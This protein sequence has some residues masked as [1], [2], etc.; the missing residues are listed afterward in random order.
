MNLEDI[1]KQ[2][3]KAHNRRLEQQFPI[4][5]YRHIKDKDNN[6]ETIWDNKGN[7]VWQG[8]KQRDD[9]HDAGLPPVHKPSL[10]HPGRKDW[11]ETMQNRKIAERSLPNLGK[12][13]SQGGL[14][15]TS[16]PSKQ[17]VQQDWKEALRR[18]GQ[19]ERAGRMPATGADLTQHKTEIQNQI[20]ELQQNEQKLKEQ[21]ANLQRG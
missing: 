8:V 11:K 9:L 19:E 16:H 12:P 18:K 2:Y 3:N 6:T 20:R 10:F 13:V 5:Q 17:R 1:I 21:L 14:P 4:A 7:K 15:K